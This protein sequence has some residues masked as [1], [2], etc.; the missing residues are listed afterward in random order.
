VR[1]L[2]IALAGLFQAVRLVQLTAAGQYRDETAWATSIHSLFVTEPETAESVYGGLTGLET[3]LECL[4]EQL[5][6]DRRVRDLELARHVITVLYLERRLG[7][8]HALR[9]SLRA[10]I[11]KAGE[12]AKFL[13]PLHPAVI[14]SLADCYRQTIS[15][16]RPRII[17]RGEQAILG[18]PDVQHRIRTLLLAAIRSAVLWRQSGGGRLT[19]LLQRRK[20][21][22]CARELLDTAHRR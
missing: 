22:E 2:A 1:S 13:D 5:G 3:G 15:T 8:R 18:N 12:Q 6:S 10:G 16:L 21:R 20:L 14:A 11:D 9:E 17:V 19:L 7:R 4:L